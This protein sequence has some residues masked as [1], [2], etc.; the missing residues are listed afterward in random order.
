MSWEQAQAAADREAPAPDDAVLPSGVHVP[1]TEPL[2][3]TDHFDLTM[4]ECPAFGAEIR[5]RPLARS[6]AIDLA[7]RHQARIFSVDERNLSMM[8]TE[9]GMQGPLRP[10]LNKA[11]Q[12][13]VCVSLSWKDRR[14]YLVTYARDG[15]S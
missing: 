7:Q 4:I 8:E 1:R 15:G 6:E 9:L 10:R 11:T 2:V 14:W 12:L 5:V 3:V 13:L